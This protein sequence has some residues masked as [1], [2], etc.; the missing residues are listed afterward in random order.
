[1]GRKRGQLH[2]NWFLY[3][4]T[5]IYRKKHEVKDAP[6][7]PSLFGRDV[8]LYDLPPSHIAVSRSTKKSSPIRNYKFKFRSMLTGRYYANR[9][10]V[11]VADS[12]AYEKYKKHGNPTSLHLNGESHGG[13]ERLIEMNKHRSSLH[14]GKLTTIKKW[15]SNP[16]YSIDQRAIGKEVTSNPYRTASIWD[17]ETRKKLSESVKKR[18]LKRNGKQI[19]KK[20][21]CMRVPVGQEDKIVRIDTGVVHFSLESV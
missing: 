20:V 5:E 13:K 1:M 10:G 6:L 4:G 15:Y 14:P 12:V 17:D 18:G 8:R 19:L 3:K 21:E 11:I 2:D 9:Y 7:P 16:K